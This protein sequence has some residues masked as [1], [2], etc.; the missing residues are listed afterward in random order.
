[1]GMV[2]PWQI[3]SDL[4]GRNPVWTAPLT[5]EKRPHG[6]AAM[7]SQDDREDRH[8]PESQFGNQQ[9]SNEDHFSP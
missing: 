4:L 1:M 5:V 2:L 6:F 3:G 9:V 7:G 8:D